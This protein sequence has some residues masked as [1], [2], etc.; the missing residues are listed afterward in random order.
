MNTSLP[1]SCGG[2]PEA[3]VRWVAET[4]DVDAALRYSSS[5]PRE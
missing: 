1:A 3:G 5:G 2:T 4:A